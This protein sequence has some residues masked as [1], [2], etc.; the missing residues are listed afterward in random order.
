MAV[1]LAVAAGV[2]IK[3]PEFFGVSMGRRGGHDLLCS[4]PQPFRAPILGGFS[5]MEA[6]AAHRLAGRVGRGVHE[7][8]VGDEPHAFRA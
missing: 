7:C 1:G 8:S 5:R 6:G 2:A 4:Q 3:I